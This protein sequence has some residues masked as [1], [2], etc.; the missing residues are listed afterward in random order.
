MTENSNLRKRV[1]LRLVGHPAVL[2]PVVLG[3]SAS[4]ALWTLANQAAL[5]WFAAIAGLLTSLGVYLTRAILDDGQTARKVLAEIDR[6]AQAARETA[7]DQLDKQLVKADRDP[8]PETALRDLRALL[9]AFEECASQGA[10]REL[11]TDVEVRA[12]VRQL[13]DHSVRSL[14][15]TMKLHETARQLQLPEARKPLLDQREQILSDVHAGIKQL[16]TTLVALQRLGAGEQDRSELARLRGE[17]DQSLAVAQR[18]EQR[19]NNLFATDLPQE[20]PN[21]LRPAAEQPT[22]GD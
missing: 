22:K 10:S 2:A 1:L 8:R 3:A 14:E 12:R 7:L 13:F 21:P 18:V 11:A 6:E 16:G 5:G 17:L 4:T 19:L 15:S 9:R 20:N